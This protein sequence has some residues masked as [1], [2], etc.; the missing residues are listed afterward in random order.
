MVLEK[1]YA[2]KLYKVTKIKGYEKTIVHP[3]ILHC[4]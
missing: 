4:E 3:H 1:S 2:I